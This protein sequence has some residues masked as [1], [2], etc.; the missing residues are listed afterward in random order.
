MTTVHSWKSVGLLP[1]WGMGEHETEFWHQR[2]PTA[3]AGEHMEVGGS[4]GQERG[5]CS[6]REIWEVGW[7][8]G[9][10]GKEVGEGRKLMCAV[11]T[12][13]MWGGGG[14]RA[15]ENRRKIGWFFMNVQRE[16]SSEE[17]SRYFKSLQ[18]LRVTGTE[19]SHR[20]LYF[21]ISG[22]P[23]PWGFSGQWSEGEPNCR[24]LKRLGDWCRGGRGREGG[25][26]GSVGWQQCFSKSA[27]LLV[28]AWS[29]LVGS[30]PVHRRTSPHPPTQGVTTRKCLRCQMPPRRQIPRWD[31]VSRVECRFVL[32][33]LDPAGPQ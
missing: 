20:I 32:L 13:T 7:G 26:S 2:M 33:L 11:L 8:C 1:P 12:S 30:C 19:K 21:L 25:Q 17:S 28:W 18:N 5:L 6:W 4:V 29:S 10:G 31:L 3:H 24:A 15:R 23:W 22:H 14:E 16:W 9:R 27:R